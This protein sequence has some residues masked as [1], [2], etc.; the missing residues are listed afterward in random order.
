MQKFKKSKMFREYTD[1]QSGVVSYVLDLPSIP[2]T[3]SFYFTNPSAT[4]DG[5]YV[6]VYVAFPPAGNATFGRSLAVIDTELDTFNHYPETM[7]HDASP[8]VDTKTGVIYFANGSGIWKRSPNPKDKV[9]LVAPLPDFM[10][11]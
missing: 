3:Q 10:K 2:H 4:D 5:R 11:G 8:I 1:P 7:F 6:W 9:Q